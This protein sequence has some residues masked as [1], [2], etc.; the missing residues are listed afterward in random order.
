M[1]IVLIHFK[2][3]PVYKPHYIIVSNNFMELSVLL[4]NN[5]CMIIL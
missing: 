2:M 3:F 4:G 5:S 1:K